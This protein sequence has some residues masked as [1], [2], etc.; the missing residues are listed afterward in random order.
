MKVVINQNEFEN[1]QWNVSENVG[2]LAFNS[3]DSISEILA[4]IGDG[5]QIEVY[6][7]N[8]DLVSTWYSKGVRGIDKDGTSVS[9]KF[10]VSIL[11]KNTEE[12]LQNGIDDDADAIMELAEMI[13]EMEATLDGQAEG[14]EKAQDDIDK[15]KQDISDMQDDVNDV[16]NR[17]DS[18]PADILERFGALW[19]NY[20]TLADRVAKLENK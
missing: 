1:A 4:E 12:E 7:D 13:S 19:T 17:M 18:I 10:E 15:A 5:E 8:D 6:N 3:E 2:V 14:I 20:N 9:V 11:D 16:R